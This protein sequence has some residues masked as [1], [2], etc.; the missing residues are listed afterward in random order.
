[1]MIILTG[2]SWYLIVVLICISLMG[3]DVEHFF[4]V[5]TGPL[6]VFLGEVSVRVLY[7]FLNWSVCLPGVELCEF[8]IYF[9]DQILFQCIIGNY[10]LPY[11]QFSFHFDDGFFSCAKTF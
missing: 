8:F 7:P 5:S 1:M 10:V 9:G 4:H 11:R 2:V 6:Y 3:G